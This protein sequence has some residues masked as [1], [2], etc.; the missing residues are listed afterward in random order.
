MTSRIG[1]IFE[2]I[3]EAPHEFQPTIHVFKELSPNAFRKKLRPADRGKELGKNN[4]PSPE[5]TN[6]DSTE[7]DIIDV[8][9]TRCTADTITFQEH[10]AIFKTRLANLNITGETSTIATS[11]EK[12]H[13]RLEEIVEEGLD[14]LHIL[15]KEM[16]EREQDLSRFRRKNEIDRAAH[17][18]EFSFKVFLGGVIAVLFLIESLANAGFLAKG[19]EYGLVGAYIEAFAISA[20]NLFIPLFFFSRFSR[21]ANHTSPV[22]RLLGLLIVL[23]FVAFAITLNLGVGHYREVSGVLI[24]EA[25]TAVIERLI[26]EPLGLNEG[27]S[28][29]LVFVGLLFAFLA[30]MDGWQQDDPYP[31]YGKMTRLFKAAREDYEGEKTETVRWVNDSF[32]EAIEE[33]EGTQLVVGKLR[34]EHEAILESRKLLA[35]S[36]EQQMDH[37]ERVGNTLIAEYR[38]A[39]IIARSDGKTP[40][41]YSRRWKMNRPV[42]KLDSSDET[43][44]TERINSLANEAGARLK[45]GVKSLRAAS[46]TAIEKFRRLDDLLPDEQNDSHFVLDSW[47]GS[48]WQQDGNENGNDTGHKLEHTTVGMLPE[49]DEESLSSHE[50]PQKIQTG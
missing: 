26:T 14:K 6:P 17:Y 8:V 20:A 38:E 50:D 49:K 25:G 44:S 2:G 48:Q 46:S 37:L 31:G 11:L 36:F 1:K 9:K 27:Q 30:F 29:L 24:G 32:E 13:S 5:S 34:N 22:W 21:Y 10:L 4:R 12:A 3:Q 35:R 7:L 40:K 23:G 45:E 15:R 18:P 39:N 16:F 42:I 33:I 19:N 43:L 47:R 41:S 28:W